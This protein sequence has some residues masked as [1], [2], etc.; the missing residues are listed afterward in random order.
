MH[1]ARH[2]KGFHSTEDIRVE[3][4]FHDVASTIHEFLPRDHHKHVPFNS[5]DEGSIAFDD[6]ASNIHQ[7]LRGVHHEHRV[8]PQL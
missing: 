7:S 3:H 2:V 8:L 5:R 6:V 4:A 1:S